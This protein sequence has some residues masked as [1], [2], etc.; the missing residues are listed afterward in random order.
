VDQSSRVP[1][2][3]HGLTLLEHLVA[4]FPYFD[5]DGWKARI[6]EGRLFVEGEVAAADRRLAKGQLL[7]YRMPPVDEPP[8]DLNWSVAAEDEWFLVANKPG[9]LLVH[10]MGKSYTS[11]LV[12]QIRTA[13]NPGWAAADP[14]HRLD[15]ETS[16]LVLFAKTKPALAAV[17]NLFETR[18]ITKEYVALVAPVP[19]ARVPAD[20]E[21]GTVD[22]PIGSFDDPVRGQIQ[23]VGV[24]GARAAVTH[25]RW[26]PEVAPGRYQVNVGLETG[27]T[28][29]IRVHLASQGWPLV[30]DKVYGGVHAPRHALHARRLAFVHP[31]TGV[32]MAYEAPLPPDWDQL[33]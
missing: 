14:A 26:G 23:A 9:N 32:P 33:A 29:Q 28:H 4:R 2:P 3:S 16:G 13:D 1:R 27:R 15:R 22:L 19:G 12:Y 30:G 5:A 8:A 11:N 24:P 21:G 20:G 6:A 10:R 18:A 31:F 7:T 17:L 25:W